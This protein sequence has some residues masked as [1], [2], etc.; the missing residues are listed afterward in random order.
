MLANSLRVIAPLMVKIISTRRSLLKHKIVI[1]T[2]GAVKVSQIIV[3]V[4]GI[5]PLS[6]QL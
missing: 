3:E 6:I 1:L 5:K 4:R 2:M